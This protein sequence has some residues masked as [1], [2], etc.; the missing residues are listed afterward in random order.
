MKCVKCGTEMELQ[1]KTLLEECYTCPNKQC[2]NRFSRSTN[3]AKVGAV[4]GLAALG[5]A[6]LELF[7]EAGKGASDSGS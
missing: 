2:N 3:T 7:G 1:S 6:V 4:G 5:L